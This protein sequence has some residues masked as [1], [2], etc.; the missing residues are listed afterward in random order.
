M[1]SGTGLIPRLWQTINI[2]PGSSTA[3]LLQSLGVII[4]ETLTSKITADAELPFVENGVT[5]GR[6]F[7]NMFKRLMGGISLNTKWTESTTIGITKWGISASSRDPRT[8]VIKEALQNCKRKLQT[9]D[10]A[11]A[12]PR[13]RF[14]IL[15]SEGPV[16][17][18]NCGYGMGAVKFRAQLKTFGAEISEDESRHIIEVYRQTYPHI[19]A[20]WRQAQVMLDALTKDMGAPLGKEGVLSTVPSERAIKLPSGLLMRYEKLHPVQD[21]GRVQYQYKTRTGWKKIYGGKVIENVC[22]AIARCIIG[23]QMINIAKKYDVVLTVHDAIACIVKKEDI[24]EAQAYVEE[25]MRWT[26]EW[27]T[28]LPVNCESGEGESYG[29][30]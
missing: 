2:E 15:T 22:Q 3:S 29:D 13:N 27:A 7:S 18:H 20:L 14:T 25:C 9:Y 10:L 1:K 16:I 28:G 5:I 24:K 11:Y 26:H 12:G 4:P 19:V 21:N 8:C 17:V 30:C 23:E 6:R